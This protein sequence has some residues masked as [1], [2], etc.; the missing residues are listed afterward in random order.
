MLTKIAAQNFKAFGDSPGLDVSLSEFNVFLGQN[1]SGKTSAVDAVAVL[2]QTARD[3]SNT[4]GLKWSGELIDLS[5][6]GEYA[7][8]N[9]IV[10]KVLQLQVEIPTRRLLTQRMAIP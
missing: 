9:G 3:S 2:V 5:A 10:G 8:H 4:L 7:I 6:S 1:N